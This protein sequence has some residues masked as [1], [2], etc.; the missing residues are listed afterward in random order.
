M[1]IIDT[2]IGV[3]VLMSVSPARMNRRRNAAP[4]AT[5]VGVIAIRNGYNV[6]NTTSIT[7][8]QVVIESGGMLVS[9]KLFKEAGLSYPNLI[10]RLVE[11]ALERQ[12]EKDKNVTV[13]EGPRSA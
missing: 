6:T 5:S 1:P 4:T 10:N 11:L 12:G 3:I 13:F 2:R 9:P 7:V 8:D